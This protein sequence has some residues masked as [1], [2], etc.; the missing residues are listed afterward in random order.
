MMKYFPL[1]CYFLKGY[2]TYDTVVMKLF[3]LLEQGRRD[4]EYK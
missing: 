1:A 2:G 4:V 3:I